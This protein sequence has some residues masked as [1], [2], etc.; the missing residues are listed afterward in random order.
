MLIWGALA[1]MGWLVAAL[2][3]AVWPLTREE[4]LVQWL[5][6]H[7]S[8][9]W[10]EITAAMSWI[11]DT[12]HIIITL[13]VVAV[14]FRLVFHRWRESAFVVAA[15][16]MQALAFVATTAVVSRTRPA[17]EHLDVSPPTSSFP[18][19]HAGAALALYG[20]IALVLA[21]HTRRR[22]LRPLVWLVLAVPPACVAYARLYRGMHFP[23]DVAGS[24]LNSAVCIT[25]A[26]RAILFAALPPQLGDVLDTSF[27]RRGA[28]IGPETAAQGRG[29]SDAS[30]PGRGA[31]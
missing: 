18:S 31:P 12:R 5:E 25:L 10:N 20:S 17:V 7:R 21:W 3:D 22:W 8:P 27:R 30:A 26:A 16:S 4:S 28:P 11:A 23:S 24:L 15:V 6:A 2:D 29:S 9:R 14:G 19:G 13:V 1:V